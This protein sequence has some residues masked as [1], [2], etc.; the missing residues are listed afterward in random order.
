MKTN[1]APKLN[2]ALVSKHLSMCA[3][4][5]AGT[6]AA[7]PAV[8]ATVVTN[9]INLPVPATFAGVYLNFQTGATAATGAA[10]P[11]FDFNPYAATGPLLA[12]Y[13]GPAADGGGG[14]GSAGMFT[15]LSVGAVVSSASSFLATAPGA[16]ASANFRTTGTHILGFR[17]LNEATGVLNYG[18][19]R[20]STTA[21][22]GFPATVL[23][24]SYENNGGAI[25]VAPVPEPATNA[26]LA[27]AALVLGAAGVREWRRQAVA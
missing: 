22:T 13:W 23:S 8:E 18:Y 27:V 21:T 17:F 4:A 7:V 16:S 25:T 9:D 19:L 10:L 15:D 2:A 14:V 26:L 3:A 20:I 12:F 6:A 11:G 1:P 5:L 24:Y